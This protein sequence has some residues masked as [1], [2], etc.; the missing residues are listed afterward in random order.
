M[1]NVFISYDSGDWA[2]VQRLAASLTKHG[3]NARTHGQ[4][5]R[6]SGWLESLKDQVQQSDG[7]VL[8]MPET[9]A[10][11]SNNAF[12][13]A[14]VARALG[15]DVVVVVPDMQKVDGSNIPVDIAK[16]IVIDAAKQSPESL[17]A[18]VLGTFEN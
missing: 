10:G 14:G 12:F 11:S 9:T 3:F 17:A 16:A 5:R 13:E 18:T 15:K 6:G 8:V 2:F 1:K 4:E 7:L